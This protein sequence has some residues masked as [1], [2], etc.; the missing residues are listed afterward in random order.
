[1]ELKNISDK[2]C[3]KNNTTKSEIITMILYEMDD[4]PKQTHIDLVKKGYITQFGGKKDYAVTSKGKE[5]LQNVL[6]ESDNNI[7]ERDKWI[8]ELAIQLKEVYPKGKKPGT[9]YY[10]SDSIILIA[11]RLKQFFKK[12]DCDFNMTKEQ[13]VNATKKYVDSFNGIYTYM[14]LLKYFI[15]KEKRN[16]IGEIE[17]QSELLTYIENANEESLKR[18]FSE[19]RYE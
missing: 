2:A 16:D 12:Y 7:I 6:L 1:M 9:N 13:I 5:V 10:W 3:I 18:D 4:T 19:M 15:F 14:Q 11:K 8:S 17:S